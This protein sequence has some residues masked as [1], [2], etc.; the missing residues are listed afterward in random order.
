MKA[1]WAR[2]A[3]EV[4]DEE[5]N[6]FY[7]HVSHDWTDPLETIHMKAEGTFEY[8]A[9]LFI[10]SRAPFDLFTRDGKRGVQLYVKRVFIMD[11]CEALMPELPALRQ[12][13]RRRARPVAQRLPRDPAAGPPDP[14]HPPA[15]GEE[16]ARRRSRT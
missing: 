9:L 6:E 12:G 7:K 2:P 13:R 11:D 10:P 4:N 8:E 1:L 16:G 15:P 14:D 5:Y 3:D